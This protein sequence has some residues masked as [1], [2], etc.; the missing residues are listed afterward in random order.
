MVRGAV[1]AQVVDALIPCVEGAERVVVAVPDTTRR[2]DVGQA[3]RALVPVLQGRQVH[4]LVGLGLHRPLTDAERADLTAQS[5]WPVVEHAPDDCV[6]LGQ[7]PCPTGAIPAWVHPLVAQADA[8]VAVGIVE[9]HQYAG[10][11]GGHKAVAVGLGGR[12]TLAALHARALVCHPRVV[13]GQVQGNP[14]RQA[15]DDLGRLAG[16]TGALQVLPDGTW[17]AGPT[18]ATFVAAAQ[19]LSPWRPGAGLHDRVV[20]D[21]PPAK[22]V[23][24]YQASRAAT[25][26]ALSPA[27][28]LRPGAALVLNAACPEGMGHGSGEQAFA[29]LLRSTPP[30]WQSLLT[31]P[32]P[33][34]AGLQRAYMLARLA[35]RYSLQIRG[36]STWRVLADH[37]LDARPEPPGPGGLRVRTPFQALPQA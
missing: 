2:V 35:Q 33:S 13:V 37:G 32:V 9:V 24:F 25:Y 5:P 14:F 34:G 17:L 23:N 4:V 15:V 3:L 22:A 18:D 21:L 20:L 29:A 8:S 31:G 10:F 16:C 6:H 12:A 19:A 1:A 28:P 11:S 27:P 26:L 30:P 36:C 7:V